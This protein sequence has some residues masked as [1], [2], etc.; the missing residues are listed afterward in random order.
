MI[1]LGHNSKGGAPRVRWHPKIPKSVL[2]G[3]RFAFPPKKCYH[4]LFSL[5]S[6]TR[7]VDEKHCR[8]SSLSTWR[9]ATCAAGW[10]MRR[11]CRTTW[12]CGTCSWRRPPTAWPPPWPKW[13]T[14]WPGL[15]RRKGAG[16][17]CLS[18]VFHSG[19]VSVEKYCRIY[20][21][22]PGCRGVCHS[23]QV[24]I[25]T[26]LFGGICTFLGNAFFVKIP[27]SGLSFWWCRLFGFFGCLGVF[28]FL[29]LPEICGCL[30][31]GMIPGQEDDGQ[32]VPS[33]GAFC[34]P[35]FTASL[36]TVRADPRPAA[37]LEATAAAPAA[38]PGPAAFP[39]GLRVLCLARPSPP[40]PN[41][42]RPL[43][44]AGVA[45]KTA[46]TGRKFSGSNAKFH[47]KVQ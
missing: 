32:N 10:G 40:S 23:F 35:T 9:R 27:R 3:P 4:T 24:F 22:P 44:G 16:S 25:E 31:L 38:P 26:S 39:P 8:R 5:C 14:W 29:C 47:E 15:L 6:C 45:T 21:P 28:V 46:F 30:I 20:N 43:A 7:H 13:E 33:R 12:G 42:W 11:C 19:S 41:G 34:G 17:G 36:E 1:A 18:S 37:P 2:T